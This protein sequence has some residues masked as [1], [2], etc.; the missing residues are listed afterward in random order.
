MTTVT[1]KI[2]LTSLQ[3]KGFMSGTVIKAA[4]AQVLA[5][6]SSRTDVVFGILVRGRA[7]YEGAE[8]A[9]GVC[10][11]YVPVPTTRW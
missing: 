7:L 6:T 1:E 8:N 10:V 9:A 4:W 11:N 2:A 5:A 3:T